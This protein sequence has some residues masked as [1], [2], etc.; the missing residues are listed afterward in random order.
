[1]SRIVKVRQ[2]NGEHLHPSSFNLAVANIDYPTIVANLS[3][4]RE[5]LKKPATLILSGL[6]TG[7]VIPLH[8]RLHHS[9][10]M[11]VA[12]LGE[13]AWAALALSVV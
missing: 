13:E 5:S 2:G 9:G 3:A 11:P 10:L 7:D 1:V 8:E 12:V 6:L 4:L